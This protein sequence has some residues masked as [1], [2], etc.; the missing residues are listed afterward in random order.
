MAQGR[1]HG[2]ET[3][4]NHAVGSPLGPSGFFGR[5]FHALPVFQPDDEDLVRLAQTMREPVRVAGVD[6]QNLLTGFTSRP[7]P[8]L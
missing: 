3:R 7:V 1:T 2:A 4:G 5:M 6:N 8:A